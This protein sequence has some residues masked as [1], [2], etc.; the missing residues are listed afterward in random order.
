MKKVYV[1]LFVLVFSIAGFSQ[2][3]NRH[4]ALHRKAE[5]YIKH[6]EFVSAAY[7]LKKIV[8]R[9]PQDKIARERLNYCYVML[10]FREAARPPYWRQSYQDNILVSRDK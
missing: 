2:I 7:N 3:P 10:N 4:K 5:K 6:C 9:D 8:N 1:I